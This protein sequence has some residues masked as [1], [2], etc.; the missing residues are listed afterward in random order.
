MEEL[1][2]ILFQHFEEAASKK[3]DLECQAI[4][5]IISDAGL[6]AE[7]DEYLESRKC[8]ISLGIPKEIYDYIR[9]ESRKQQMTYADYEHD[10]AEFEKTHPGE[11]NVIVCRYPELTQLRRTYT[12]HDHCTLV[13]PGDDKTV[14]LLS[15]CMRNR[16]LKYYDID[17]GKEIKFKRYNSK[18]L[19][20][21]GNT[22]QI[23]Y[24]APWK[25]GG[26]FKKAD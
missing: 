12:S 1:K 20:L 7:F 19:P 25:L 13:G 6:N 10:K 17:S 21:I 2:T 26:K 3:L 18:G 22:N 24:D 16:L 9:R 8:R 5:S 4:Y 23:D 15:R 11:T 14:G